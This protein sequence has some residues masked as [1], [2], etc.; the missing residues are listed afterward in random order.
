MNKIAAVYL[1]RGKDTPWDTFERFFDSYRR[2]AAGCKHDLVVM[3]KGW[4]DAT[5]LEE[6]KRLSA[7]VTSTYLDL[8]DDGFDWGAYFR[9]TEK[10]THDSLCFLNTYSEILHQGWL[11]N[12]SAGLE[13]QNVG[14]V[15]C[16][17]SWES[18]LPSFNY[19][20]GY[21]FHRAYSFKDMKKWLFNHAHFPQYP[22]PHLRSNAFLIRRE[23][24]LKYVA[25]RAIPTN[26][27][28]AYRLESGYSGLTRFLCKQ[29]TPPMLAG[30]D[31]RYHSINEWDTSRTFRQADCSNLLV[32]DNQTRDFAQRPESEKALF[33]A[34]TWNR[35]GIQRFSLPSLFWQWIVTSL[36]RGR[37][38]DN[39][40]PPS[41]N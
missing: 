15:G 29:G 11:A 2:H 27:Q 38:K 22:N 17:G 35:D 30:V 40:P 36:S 41:C 25:A 6:F 3:L 12:L 23:T 32:A 31:G 19:M 8:P 20:A 37:G 14:A 1:A 33:M 9:A 28:Q 10:L 16:T 18:M 26:K 24:M 39:E 5:R 7:D 13:R 34:S 4:E 21:F